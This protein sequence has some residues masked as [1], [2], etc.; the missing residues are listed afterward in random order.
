MCYVIA[1]FILSALFKICFRLKVFG[2]ENFPK[3]GPLIVAPNHASFL[4]PM[5]VGVSAPVK[6]NYLARDSLFRNRFFAKVLYRVNTFPLKREGSGDIN[7]FKMSL[8]KLSQGKAL[9]I[10]P[11]GTRSED[12]SLQSPKYG[13]GFLEAR[14]GAKILPCYVKG[15]I[16]AL[17]RHSIFPRFRPISVYFG[18]V[19]RFEERFPGD[20]KKRYM[21]VGDR[22]M[23]AIDKL[24]KDAD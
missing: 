20:K 12:G 18:E 11:E 21:Y 7:A 3:E 2:K 16:D 4:D 23:A 5:L 17:P 10:F 14:S 8:K 13:I 9:L 1:R 24:K 22:V 15:S 19:L 6:L